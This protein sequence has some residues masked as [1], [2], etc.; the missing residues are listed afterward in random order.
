MSTNDPEYMK[1]WREDNKEEVK[2]K[3]R[4]YYLANK[5]HIKAKS[6]ERRKEYPELIAANKRADYESKNQHRLGKKKGVVPAE[7]KVC[8]CCEKNKPRSEYFKKLTS[9]SHLCKPCSNLNSVDRNRKVRNRTPKWADMSAIAAIYKA[10]PEGH[11]V[12]HIIPIFGIIDG[13]PVSGL[14]VPYN[15]QYLPAKKNMSKQNYITEADL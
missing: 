3:K 1:K 8:P 12:D 7:F 15:L 14:H 2:R 4:E 10:R 11:H 13:R 5:E 6:A 9:I